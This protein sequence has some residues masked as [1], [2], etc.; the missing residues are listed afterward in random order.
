LEAPPP[1]KLKKS[2]LGTPTME[3]IEDENEGDEANKE[4]NE[5]ESVAILEGEDESD[6]DIG[7]DDPEIFEPDMAEEEDK[8]DSANNEVLNKLTKAVSNFSF[9]LSLH[10]SDWVLL[11]LEFLIK[12]IPSYS[13]WR[14]E[15]DQRAK[16]KNLR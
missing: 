11:Q 13:A 12:I 8:V 14:Q 9:F 1:P 7:S 4:N 16:G 10:H 3:I 6:D 2:F 15:F 5:E